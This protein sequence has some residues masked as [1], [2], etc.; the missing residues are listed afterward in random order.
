MGDAIIGHVSLRFE[1]VFRGPVEGR[2]VEFEAAE[3]FGESLKDLLGGGGDFDSDAVA[4]DGGYAV[5][6]GDGADMGGHL[7]GHRSRRIFTISVLVTV[8]VERFRKIVIA[9]RSSILPY[10]AVEILWA[11]KILLEPLGSYITISAD[12]RSEQHPEVTDI[13]PHTLSVPVKHTGI[14]C[15]TSQTSLPRPLGLS[16]SAAP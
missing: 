12:V 13:Y 5:D 3:N 14:V 15:R 1:K 6:F 11:Y 9:R 4:G 7:E 16:T 2:E 10:D 8:V